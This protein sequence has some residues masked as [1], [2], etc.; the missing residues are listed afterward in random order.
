M[1]QFDQNNSIPQQNIQYSQQPVP[2]GQS[3][4]Q[5]PMYQNPPQQNSQNSQNLSGIKKLLKIAVYITSLGVI[6]MSVFSVILMKSKFSLVTIF[7]AIY[8]MFVIVFGVYSFSVSLAHFFFLVNLSGQIFLQISLFYLH[9]KHVGFLL[10]CLFFIVITIIMIY[11]KYWY[12]LFWYDFW[13]L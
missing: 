11:C 12:N 9:K 1:Y 2:V 7:M 10:R 3:V 5:N 13:R 4:E 6:I 8:V